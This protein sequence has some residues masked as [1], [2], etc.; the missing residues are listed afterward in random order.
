MP[1]KSR[2]KRGKNLPPSKRVKAGTVASAAKPKTHPVEPA[3]AA[4]VY[5]PRSAQKSLPD[6]QAQVVS[7]KYTHIKSELVTIGILAVIMLAA[8]GILAAVV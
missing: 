2:R 7:T 4:P 1:A 8:L 3:E 5:Q 6:T